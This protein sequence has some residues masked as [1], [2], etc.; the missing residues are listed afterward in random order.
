MKRCLV[1]STL[2][3]CACGASEGGAERPQAATA[4]VARDTAGSD[5]PP[6]IAA[7]TDPAPALASAPGEQS[8]GVEGDGRAALRRLALARKPIGIDG[9]LEEASASEFVADTA[10]TPSAYAGDYHFGESEGESTLTLTVKGNTVTGVLE[11]ADWVNKRWVGR[12]LRLDGGRIDGSMLVAPGW[13]GVFVRYE[14]QPGLVI[15]RAPTNLLRVE[16]GVKLPV[17]D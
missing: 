8:S 5:V 3:L 10:K 7:G 13:S 11:Y 9:G 12:Q 4:G 1:F 16:L 2:L 14:G 6:A 15:L 17:Q